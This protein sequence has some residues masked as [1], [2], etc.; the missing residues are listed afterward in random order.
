MQQQIGGELAI[1]IQ[2]E[3]VGRPGCVIGPLDVAFEN[4]G[5]VLPYIGRYHPLGFNGH[6]AIAAVPSLDV[7]QQGK[8]VKGALLEG[9]VI[10]VKAVA[11]I[12]TEKDLFNHALFG[13][14][15]QRVDIRV[16]LEQRPNPAFNAEA[17][18]EPE[19]G[20]VA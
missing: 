2:A 20:R 11:G 15:P 12:A 4:R 17:I 9:E 7:E 18:G 6:P 5:H 3:L 16:G 10:R 8:L 19:V 1:D 13:S 14:G